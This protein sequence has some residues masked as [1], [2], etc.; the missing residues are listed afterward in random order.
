MKPRLIFYCQPVLGMGHL[1][2]SLAILQ[3][4]SDFEIWF[5]NGGLPISDDL[6]QLVPANIQVVELPPL[7]SDPDFQELVPV[8]NSPGTMVAPTVVADRQSIE[9]IWER[10]RKILLELLERVASEILMIELYPFGRLKFDAELRPWLEAARERPRAPR[11]VCSLRDILVEKRDQTGFEEFAVTTANRFFDLILIHSDPQFQRLDET[12]RPLDQLTC[13]VEYTGYITRPP[14]QSEG[15]SPGMEPGVVA[16][17]G[18]G[19][20]GV[21][22]LWSTIRASR[23][24]Q[25]AIPHHLTIFTGPYLPDTDLRELIAECASDRQIEV[26]RFTP[27]LALE[28]SCASLSI[29]LAGYNTCMDIIIAGVPAIVLPFTGNNNLEQTRRARKLAAMGL[30]QIISPHELSAERLAELMKLSLSRPRTRLSPAID[31]G[32]VEKTARIL[33]AIA[34]GNW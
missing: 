30:V 31:L 7:Q 2:R 6:Q 26:K 5:V 25:P 32:G 8:A 9:T 16:S 33:G 1:V 13:R 29:S 4:L 12:F 11:I 18:G 3:G 24:L 14:C 27:D 23:L 34:A 15:S 21:E 28:M 20:V 19:R 17:I 22:L 10:R